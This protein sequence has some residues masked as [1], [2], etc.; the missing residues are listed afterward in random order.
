MPRSRH[1]DLS[2]RVSP[3]IFAAD[4][5]T[6]CHAAAL[7]R[8]QLTPSFRRHTLIADADDAAAEI[9]RCR[10][11]FDDYYFIDTPLIDVIIFSPLFAAFRFR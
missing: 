1:I 8:C 5:I 2:L 6:R 10:C 4:T 11:C 9:R 7:F 3:L